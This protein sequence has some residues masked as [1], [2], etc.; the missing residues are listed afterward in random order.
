MPNMGRERIMPVPKDNDF[1]RGDHLLLTGAGSA[2]SRRGG[3]QLLLGELVSDRVLVGSEVKR[4]VNSYTG[5]EIFP[6]QAVENPLCRTSNPTI[7]VLH[8]RHNRFF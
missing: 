6:F 7:R 3:D 2:Y 1:L 8:Q 5:R 4:A